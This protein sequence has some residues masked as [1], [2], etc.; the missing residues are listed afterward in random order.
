MSIAANK[1]A[2]SQTL[3]AGIKLTLLALADHHNG[4]SGKCC[5]SQESLAEKT[6]HSV[7]TIQRHLK[8]LISA[9]LIKRQ[10]QYRNSYRTADAYT[11]ALSMED[12]TAPT[13]NQAY[14]A[15]CGLSSP[16]L[17]PQGVG[18]SSAADEQTLHRIRPDLTPQ[19]CGVHIDEPEEPERKNVA[20]E[21]YLSQRSTKEEVTKE[22]SL[23]RLSVS[24]RQSDLS[25][26]LHLC[27]YLNP[28]ADP[29]DDSPVNEGNAA[30]YIERFFQLG[31]L[32]RNGDDY[33][34]TPFGQRE[35]ESFTDNPLSEISRVRQRLAA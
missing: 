25:D 35:L 3:D 18:V 19:W 13:E 7:D 22:E 1:W 5:P 26:F 15:P 27:A 6:G 34:T 30:R 23:T 28:F 11:L 8:A 9:K 4:K 10:R 17:T 29:A 2:W 24:I 31:Y 14:T 21:E 20:E 16:D 32:Q 12:D 33:I